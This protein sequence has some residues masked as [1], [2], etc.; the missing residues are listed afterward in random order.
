MRKRDVAR[1]FTEYVIDTCRHQGWDHCDTCPLLPYCIDA[2][3]SPSEVNDEF[4]ESLITAMIVIW[5]EMRGKGLL[6][7]FEQEE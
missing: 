5:E 1:R 4:E 6:S 2:G 7:K 3:G